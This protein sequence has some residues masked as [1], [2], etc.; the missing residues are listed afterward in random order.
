MVCEKMMDTIFFYPRV[1]FL[2]YLYVLMT[3]ISDLPLL[4]LLQM[5]RASL[6]ALPVWPVKQSKDGDKFYN[7]RLVLFA[8][9]SFRVVA[10]QVLL[11]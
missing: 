1:I 7:K 4:F 9:L 5:K 6:S 8:I 10:M 2:L 3:K 11:K